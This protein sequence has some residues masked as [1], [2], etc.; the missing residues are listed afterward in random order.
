MQE[1]CIGWRL[2]Q[3]PV[4]AVDDVVNQ[5]AMEHFMSATLDVDSPSDIV[6]GSEQEAVLGGMRA[7][8]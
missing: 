2:I 3:V 8:L 7:D 5:Q 6:S 4:Q 1:F